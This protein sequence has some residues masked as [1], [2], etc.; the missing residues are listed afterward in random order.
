M[1]FIA[2]TIEFITTGV[3]FEKWVTFVSPS[4]AMRRPMRSK[5]RDRPAISAMT[6][7]ASPVMMRSNRSASA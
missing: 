1:A 7:V 4:A 5:F 3:G 2:S 6:V